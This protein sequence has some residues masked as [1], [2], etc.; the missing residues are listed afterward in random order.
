MI[1]DLTA[2][3]IEALMK[4]ARAKVDRRAE[5]GEIT[6]EAMKDVNELLGLMR[7]IMTAFAF[8]VS[9]QGEEPDEEEQAEEVQYF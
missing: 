2:E 1:I 8:M 5:A 9:Q 7:D 3:Q 6:P 4:E